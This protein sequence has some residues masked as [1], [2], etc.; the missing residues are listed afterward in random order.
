VIQSALGP[1]YSKISV[2][3]VTSESMTVFSAWEGAVFYVARL[4]G[5][6][7]AGLCL[8]LWPA[9]T[10]VISALLLPA[11]FAAGVYTALSKK[12]GHLFRA[13]EVTAV[14]PNGT[15]REKFSVWGRD[16]AGGFLM[17]WKIPIE[18]FL[19]VQV[20]LEL[21]VIIP[22][23]GIVLPSILGSQKLAASWLGWL[24]AS[25][26]AGL[27]FGSLAAPK[28]I[29][30]LKPWLACVVSAFLLSAFVLVCGLF[31]AYGNTY[32]LTGALFFANL[33]LG[34]RMQAGAAQRRVA[35][36]DA[37]RARFASIHI[38]LNSVAAQ[39]GIAAAAVLLAYESPAVW[40]F[41]SS[42]VLLGLALL[43]ARI[44]GYRELIDQDVSS[45]QG[46]YERMYPA[47]CLP[48]V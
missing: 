13:S 1:A 41:M 23:F 4:G 17:R 8:L 9:S 47:V 32:G 21:V 18:R 14:N 28:I 40:F 42:V 16:I 44:P 7:I 10:V 2:R 20:F 3:L 19:T 39:L 25:C 22:T 34:V 15:V 26:G 36:P 5:P 43:L 6:I 24:E 35:I 29:S 27:V 45:A 37:L 33:A 46:Y 48:V 12:V 38:A 11:V 31:E 30:H